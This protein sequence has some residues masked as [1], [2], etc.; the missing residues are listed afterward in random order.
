MKT[1]ISLIIIVIFAGIG[2][3]KNKTDTPN[4]IDISNWNNVCWNC[5]AKDSN[6]QF[7]Y[8]KA[9]DGRTFKDKKCLEN[10]K[11]AKKINLKIGL[12]HYF[13]TNASALNQFNNFKSI[14]DKVNTDLIPVIDVESNGNNYGNTEKVNKELSELIELY[15][16]EFGCYPII[17]IGNLEVI[18]LS[19]IFKC[20]IWIRCIGF[21][22]ILPDF[23]IKQIAVKKAGHNY[24]D[25]NYAS[26]I[27]K[28]Y[29]PY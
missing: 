18:K 1:M 8:I 3:I 12:Y 28:L 13:R 20:P 16:K 23:T 26:D 19:A 14:H 25:F 17:Y 15:H 29:K 21:A 9:T 5:I 4:G 7:C 2:Y 11:Q 10:V 22:G 6:I 24:L 27:S